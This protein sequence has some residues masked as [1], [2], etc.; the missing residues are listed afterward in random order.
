DP[1]HLTTVTADKAGAFSTTVTIPADTA[2]GAHQIVVS[3][4][5][6]KSATFDIT[7]NAASGS[8]ATTAAPSVPGA[9][10]T[11]SS[12][13]LA[14]TGLDAKQLLLVGLIFLLSGAF[15]V[16]TSAKSPARRPTR[17]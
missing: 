5:S 14:F 6:G 12:T 3:E 2:P 4:T 9:Q 10:V 16:L 17:R 13:P 15:F 11:Q 8:P 7:V 1:V